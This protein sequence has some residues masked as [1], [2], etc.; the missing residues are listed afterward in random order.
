DAHARRTER[1]ASLGTMAAGLAHQLR[2]PLNAA[3]LQLAVVMRR[4]DTADV[5]GAREAARLVTGELGRLSALVGEFLD[6]ARLQPLAPRPTELRSLVSEVLKL[7]RPRAS[8]SGV[9]LTLED[10][11]K[12]TGEV[13]RERLEQALRNLV[14]NGVDAVGSGGHVTVRV[15]G[16]E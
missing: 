3:H 12:A 8:Q 13:D 15:R 16:G 10:G 5:S 1:L 9:E 4:L 14:E 6:F 2:N 7:V 11:A